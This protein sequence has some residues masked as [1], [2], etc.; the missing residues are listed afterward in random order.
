VWCYI[1]EDGNISDKNRFGR[2]VMHS[3]ARFTYEIVQDILDGKIKPG[4]VPA[5]YG[6]IPGVDE[7]IIF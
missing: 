7:N 1:D 3:K 5:G 4:G 2:S 6:V